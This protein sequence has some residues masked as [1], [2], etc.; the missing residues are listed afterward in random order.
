MQIKSSYKSLKSDVRRRILKVF[1]QLFLMAILLFVLAGRPDW[2]WGWIYIGLYVAYIMVNLIVLPADL[3]AER[4]RVKENV[5][6]WDKQI[7]QITFIPGLGQPII[8]GLNERFGWSASLATTIHIVGASLFILGSLTLTWAMISNYYFSTMVRILSD[9][10]HKVATSGPYRIVRH[11][12]Y[13]GMIMSSV[14]SCLL[15]DF[16]WALILSGAMGILFIIRTALEDR[17]LQLELDG[18]RKFAGHTKYRLL[19]DIR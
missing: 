6:E 14:G 11:T 3:I 13:A 15:L 5:R 17:T 2:L 16:L 8:A 12:G 1:L 9:R 7:T 10:N 18:Y 4:G 19:P